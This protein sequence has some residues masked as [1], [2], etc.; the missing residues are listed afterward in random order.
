MPLFREPSAVVFLI[1]KRWGDKGRAPYE[2]ARSLGL[3]VEA[4]EVG[5]RVDVSA[6]GRLR[7]VLR[8]LSPKVVHAH[9]VKATT[10]AWLASRGEAWKRVSTHHGVEGRPDWK[11]RA[12]EYFYSQVVLPQMHMAVAVS[13]D[14]EY[15]LLRRGLNP[16][17]LTFVANGITRKLWAGEERA[18]ERARIRAEWA[19]ELP[20]LDER[21]LL[22]GILARLSAEKR[23]V[24][25]LHT[26]AALRRL[27]PELNWRLVALGSGPLE[28]TLKRTTQDLSLSDRVHWMGYRKDAS[29]LIPALDLLVFSSQAE[30]LPIAALE[31]GWAGVP[32][33]ASNVG[34]LPELIS[35][36]KTAGGVV[37]P[38]EQEHL[39]TAKSLAWLLEHPRERERMGQRLQ[40]RVRH[41][42]SAEAWVARM[43]HIYRSI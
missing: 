16:Q 24:Y 14:D 36:G 5:A 18:R 41:E 7:G 20:G 38:R 1:E 6:V 10:Y 27:R 28:G 43:E 25:L 26:L 11:T 34:G 4:V 21:T 15:A 17:A 9:D 32:V 13:R 22:V 23:H 29:S 39:H 3:R 8:W 37:F 40:N 2:Y 30:G 33:L 12:Y 19:K 35:T 42:Y 31:S